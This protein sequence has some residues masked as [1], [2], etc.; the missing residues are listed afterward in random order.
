M[1]DVNQG[2]Y[3]DLLDPDQYYTVTP[4]RPVR[5]QRIND[6]L[7][8]EG[9]FCPTIRRTDALAVSKQP[10]FPSGA[11]RSCPATRRNC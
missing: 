10:T 3:I 2:N 1:D 4:A 7:L 6:N 9:R 5:R 8:G 11:G